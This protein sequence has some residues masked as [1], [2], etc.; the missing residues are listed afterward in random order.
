MTCLGGDGYQSL[1]N[2]VTLPLPMS[3]EAVNDILTNFLQQ[4]KT[5]EPRLDGRIVFV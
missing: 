3:G 5:I 2:G 4:K 1:R